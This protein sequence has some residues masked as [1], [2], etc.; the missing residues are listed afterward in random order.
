[1]VRWRRRTVLLALPGLSGVAGL[2][3]A[4]PQ[5]A[6]VMAVAAWFLAVAGDLLLQKRRD[7]VIATTVREG[8][9]EGKAKIALIHELA[10]YEAIRSGQLASEDIVKL[11]KPASEVKPTRTW[12]LEADG[13]DRDTASNA[14]QTPPGSIS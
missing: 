9:R 12:R 14:L 1:L 8:G 2:L 7:D 4:D 5:T 3:V 10:T 11:L 13:L 6:L